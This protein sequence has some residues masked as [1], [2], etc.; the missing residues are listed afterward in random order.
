MKRNILALYIL[1]TSSI[2]AV[3]APIDDAKKLYLDGKY[4]SAITHLLPLQKKSPNDGFVNYYLGASYAAL[5]R[6]KKAVAPLKVAESKGV[7]DASRV[8]ADIAFH[9]YRVDDAAAH[10]DTWATLLRKNKR[11]A[12]ASYD[13]MKEKVAM[14]RNMLE[15]V[16]RIAVVDSLVVDANDFFTY[17][18]LAPGAGKILSPADLQIDNATI[19]YVP[20]N[21]SEII[22][23][24]PDSN[25]V[26]HL[27]HSIIL[28]NGT[29]EHADPL[30]DK[31]GLGGN[32][33]YP[34]LMADGLTLYYASDGEG[35]LGGYDIFLSRRNDNGFLQPQ[36]VGM[37]YNSPYDDYMLAIDETTG[38]GWWATDRNQIPGKVTIY[39][40]EPSEKRVNCDTDAPDLI[41]RARIT[42]IAA[43][44]D[45]D[46][47]YDLTDRIA[48]AHSS[49]TDSN[50]DREFSISM[51][52]FH[53]VYHR[54]SD[55]KNSDA[56]EYMLQL[57]DTYD[58]ITGIENR[59]AKLRAS[60]AN[61]S[62]SVDDEIVTLESLL[63]AARQ[64]ERK[65]TNTVVRLETK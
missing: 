36:N 30:D 39:I 5:N 62:Q 53:T 4:E 40:F 21:S 23:A 10:L 38:A 12:P 7:A 24:E 32:A 2:M 13:T 31:L 37:P 51:G 56:R 19:I 35:S 49:A 63:D 20:E 11:Q 15:R 9:E 29:T 64:R 14:M 8:L 28:D 1:A 42:S 44:Q 57:L 65:L 18:K 60:Y 47:T 17:Y 3:A 26:S 50:S 52:D 55:F 59:L 48:I 27:M 61:G 16:E 41:A 34:F 25:D 45:A 46:T 33:N 54:L 43:T 6:N 22:W 58:E